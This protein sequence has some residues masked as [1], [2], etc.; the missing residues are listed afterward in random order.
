M[1]SD[2][3]RPVGEAPPPLT[4][5][6]YLAL[7]EILAAQRPLT[8]EHDEL[9]FIVQHQAVEL[10]L[11]LLLHELRAA[12]DALRAGAPATA[13]R[14]LERAALVL[15]QVNAGWDLLRGLDPAAF[16]RLRQRLGTAS[17]LQSANWRALEQLVGAVAAPGAGGLYAAAL[18]LLAAR[19]HLAAAPV[20]RAA[21]LPGLGEP[22]VEAAWLAL[23]QAPERDPPLRELGERL[24]DLEDA[25]RAWRHHHLAIV[26][27]LIGGRPG[28]GG[29]GAQQ[30]RGQAEVACFPE[31]RS[32]RARL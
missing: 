10:W 6:D 19:G 2:S 11:K 27:R 23:Y 20:A 3:E 22:A 7:G 13:N 8:A 14:L 15:R 29:G 9:L 12:C 1:D 30:L 24:L 31:L 18:G 26:E 5:A 21:A 25:L 32:L 28:T 17:G 4:Y 16:A